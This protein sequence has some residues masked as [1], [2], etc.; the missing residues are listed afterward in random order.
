[1]TQTVGKDASACPCGGGDEN[2]ID[3]VVAIREVM[4]QPSSA[5]IGQLLPG[6]SSPPVSSRPGGGCARG[7][8]AVAPNPGDAIALGSPGKENEKEQPSQGYHLLTQP[9]PWAGQDL[10]PQVARL[11]WRHAAVITS[12]LTTLH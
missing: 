3:L 2:S 11:S 5:S 9:T 12:N 8:P 7:V 6:S 1:M 4:F 10:A